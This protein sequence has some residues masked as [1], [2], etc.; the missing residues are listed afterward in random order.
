MSQ[1]LEPVSQEIGKGCRTTAST[2]LKKSDEASA[3]KKAVV[4]WNVRKMNL[5]ATSCAWMETDFRGLLLSILLASP[6]GFE[7]VLP[8]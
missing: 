6:T 7:P 2:V 1:P 3:T 4:L 8:P 5:E